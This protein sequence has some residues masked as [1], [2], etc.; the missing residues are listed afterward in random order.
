MKTSLTRGSTPNRAVVDH[1]DVGTPSPTGEGRRLAWFVLFA[2]GGVLLPGAS[3][4]A[5]D[6]PLAAFGR[7]HAAW[8]NL[9]VER[10]AA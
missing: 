7:R 3:T 1:R 8:E 9:L 10:K 6:A 2:V 5:Y 4:A